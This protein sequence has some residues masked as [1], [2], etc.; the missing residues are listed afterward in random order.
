MSCYIWWVVGTSNSMQMQLMENRPWIPEF[1]VMYTLGVDGISAPMIAIT[2]LLTTW[3]CFIRRL[4]IQERV[5]EF[6]VLF[7]LLETGMLGVFLAIDFILFYVFWEIG[8][9]PMFL[10]IGIWGG[11]RREYAAIKFFSL[12]FER[13]C[14]QF[15]SYIG[16]FFPNRY[17]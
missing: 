6:Y 7:M 3:C 5:K 9:V 16:C 10:I 13:K 12:H 14:V 1:H 17:I 4:H 11:K 2:G 15:V 8:L